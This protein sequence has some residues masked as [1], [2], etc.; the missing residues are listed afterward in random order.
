MKNIA[1]VCIT[2][3]LFTVTACGA[4]AKQLH[5]NTG[6]PTFVLEG[7]IFTSLDDL[8]QKANETCDEHGYKILSAKEASDGVAVTTAGVGSVT[9]KAQL[10][11]Q[12]K[13]NTRSTRSM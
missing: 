4:K 8:F 13:G 11:V 9:D 3:L 10:V 5:S 6:G 7:S 1:I 2:A 12:C